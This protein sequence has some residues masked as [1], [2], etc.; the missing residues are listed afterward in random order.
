MTP[1][2]LTGF[3]KKGGP[4]SKSIYFDAHG[5]IT[6]NGDA[7]RMEEGTAHRV[8]I[9]DVRHLGQIISRLQSHHAIALGA[10]R[11]D[12]PDQVEIVTKRRRDWLHTS[13]K[14]N[15]E[16]TRTR[17][18]ISYRSGE[19]AF[20]LLDFDTKAMPAQVRA[21]L[22]ELGGFRAAI[23]NVVPQIG[24]CA[25]LERASTSSGLMRADT[26]ERFEG[27]GGVHLYIEVEDGGD[28]ERFLTD[29]HKRC[30]LAGL[31]WMMVGAGGQLLDRSI[32]D[33]MVGASERLVFE[34]PPILGDGLI[35][36]IELRSPQPRDGGVLDTKEYCPPLTV[37]EQSLLKKARSQEMARLA[38][39]ASKAR[40]AFIATRIAALREA[41]LPEE[42]AR[43]AV[44]RQCSGILRP[45]IVLPW[46][47]PELEGRTVCDVLAN[48]RAFE[49]ET[50]ADPL[51]GVEYGR[52][53]A[54]IM[55][56]QDG[57]PWIHS[58]A[59]GRTIYELKRDSATVRDAVNKA[60]K[61]DHVR[62]LSRLVPDADLTTDETEA[63]VKEAARL[64]GVGQRAV[65]AALKIG[66][67]SVNAAR[68]EEMRTHQLAQRTDPRV[69]LLVPKEQDAIEPIMRT[70]DHV[71]SES[72]R[73]EPPMRN[74]QGA[75][76]AK[77][78]SAPLN[79]HALAS[80][81][82]NA[83][84]AGGTPV[85]S[86][87]P[88]QVCLH[89]IGQ[90]ETSILVEHYIEYIDPDG[91]SVHL[92]RPFVR[93]YMAYARSDASH[94][95]TISAVVTLPIVL[96]DG[97]ILIGQNGRGIDRQRGILFDIPQDIVS[98]LPKKSECTPQHVSRAMNFLTEEWLCDVLTDYQGKCVL[99]AAALSL[100]ERTAFPERPVFWVT[101]ARR[102]SGKTT[103]LNMIVASALG[104]RAA[105]AAWSFNEEE[106][107]KSLLGYLMSGAAYI[108]WDNIKRGSQLSC[109]H[110][111]RCCTMPEYVDRQLGVNDNIKAPT[112]T[113]MMF[114]GNAIAPKGDLAS[115]S[116]R[117][118][119]RTERPDPENR[120]YGHPDPIAWTQDNRAK[121][122]GALYVV[123]LGNQ[124]LL[125]PLNQQMPTRFPVWHRLV[126]SAVEFAA[127]MANASG[128][129]QAT[130]VSFVRMFT[131]EDEDDEEGGE[132]AQA[133][134]I[135]W[136]WICEMRPDTTFTAAK[137]EQFINTRW[138][139]DITKA[140]HGSE[141]R[142]L[143][144][145]TNVL[146]R[147][148]A[149]QV[150]RKLSAH[151][152]EPIPIGNETIT[153]VRKPSQ[154]NVGAEY[155]IKRT[156]AEEGAAQCSVGIEATHEDSEW[157]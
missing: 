130:E 31:G 79:M 22:N 56:R 13:G 38:S 116:L 151:L 18:N 73:L 21:R 120:E 16:V 3:A 82:A 68:I 110:I 24:K 58:F 141:L 155:W 127:S 48:P 62:V 104:A 10:L 43:T 137:V 80:E 108:I 86:P 6:S 138:E 67:E 81:L 66:T 111:E 27:S 103:A 77:R 71:F 143:L 50:L 83:E 157:H 69:Q 102:G 20:A 114:T 9:G 1:I 39:S 2:V 134:G 17:E 29:L 19:P 26:R 91:R 23:E 128:N 12:L 140:R 30:W 99:I 74:L 123:L 124:T 35:Q 33:R 25:T 70:L 109:P 87:A 15:G 142:D 145:G 46:D 144:F 118:E 105:G 7:C 96:A 89:E 121:I 135:I 45:A 117:C 54:R 42:Q 100:I 75:L 150:G 136:T 148:T 52:G 44:E 11:H 98:A 51:E 95:P 65:K 133:L 57:T 32:V 36:D 72:K 85:K 119:L 55:I 49:G 37:V 106:R 153:L 5:K 4:L 59:H 88:P 8:K 61:D 152:D 90:E 139:D 78:K 122:L 97:S 125:Q 149:K 53:K 60:S 34:G 132:F 40:E 41:G 84:S 112:N 76:I 126:G 146:G 129:V 131:A 154:R 94:L 92:P 63:L 28:I 101:A 47:D 93:D 156:S 147:V 14:L 113:I 115:R 107:R 64:S